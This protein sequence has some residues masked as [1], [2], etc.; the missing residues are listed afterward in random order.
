MPTLTF[1]YT[2]AAQTWTVPAGV[3]SVN[4]DMAGAQG[5]TVT[6]DN[7]GNGGRTQ[8]TVPATPGDVWQINVGGQGSGNVAGFNGGGNGTAGGFSSKTYV[9]ASGA[10]GG[11]SDIRVP[12]SSPTLA[13][14]TV[15]AGGGGGG[16]STAGSSGSGGTGG[17]GNGPAGDTGGIGLGVTGCAG[18]GGTQVA[19]G[20]AG[21]QSGHPGNAG[22]LGVG[23]NS[24][25]HGVFFTYPGGAGGGG[26][27][28]GGGG[29]NTG[30]GGGGSSSGP[31]S[32]VYTDAFQS[33]N[34]YVTLTYAAAASSQPPA[35]AYLRRRI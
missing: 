17:G 16:G 5:A 11:A 1:N 6:G 32:P 14:R 34:G 4:V 10:G 28:G 13:N 31:G 33:G 21:T 29:V 23:G 12:N 18:G 9:P 20:V 27:Y 24:T 7:G 26:L 8:V 30:G 3:S 19:G 25:A 15:V 35:F 22:S 2:G